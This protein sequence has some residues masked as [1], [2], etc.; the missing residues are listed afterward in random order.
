MA[1]VA[2][3]GVDIQWRSARSLRRSRSDVLFKDISSTVQ[4]VQLV[5]RRAEALSLPELLLVLSL[6]LRR[7]RILTFAL[8]FGLFQL[9]I[10][11]D[12]VSVLNELLGGKDVLVESFVNLFWPPA[13]T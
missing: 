3:C 7:R 9:V 5:L 11:F 13:A 10:G 2:Q 6:L 4:D 12:P 8:R 1:C